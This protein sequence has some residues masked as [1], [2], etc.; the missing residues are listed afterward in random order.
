L[1]VIATFS[2]ALPE[3]PAG[4]AARTGF[5]MIE[6]PVNTRS[7]ALGGA[8]AAIDGFGVAVYN[9]AMPFIAGRTYLTFEFGNYAQGDMRDVLL[10]S[11]VRI[12][13]FF[14]G[15]SLRSVSIDDI[16]ETNFWG[17][18]PSYDAP[19]SSQTNMVSLHAGY[20]QWDDF[21]VAL[22]VS[23]I[24]DRIQDE[25][26]YALTGSAGAV[27]IPLPQ[28]LALGLSVMHA[29]ISTPMLGSDGAAAWGR[30]EKTP[31]NARLGAVY[32]QA[33]AAVPCAIAF[34]I[35]YR[36]VYD[37]EHGFTGEPLDRFTFPLG[38]EVRPVEQVA[39]RMG[40]RINHPVDMFNFGAGLRLDPLSVDVS[41]VIPRFVN[42]ADLKWRLNL[43][44]R[45]KTP[46]PAK[47][48]S[49]DAA[50]KPAP[51][52]AA[53]PPAEDVR[54]T[55]IPPGRESAPAAPAQSVPSVNDPGNGSG[56]GDPAAEPQ[57]GTAPAEQSPADGAPLPEPPD[58]LEGPAQ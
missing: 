14:T 31:L 50:K 17:N 24:Q 52:P 55:D 32:T 33:I 19:F 51:V 47:N 41:F 13:N 48:P 25:V 40:K 34:D 37:R 15:L 57:P 58:S 6:E 30:G 38:I 43:A 35:V 2:A 54:P 26:A 36:N 11:S 46:A 53:A 8:G 44:W 42:D 3:A 18:L 29:G 4:G 1:A 10:E 20:S 23:G 9:P 27:Y 56:S 21:A 49:Q 16:Y 45:L 28:R 39:L 5:Q 7:I 12:R 22:C